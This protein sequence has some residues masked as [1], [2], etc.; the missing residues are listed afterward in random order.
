MTTVKFAPILKR[1]AERHGGL[2]ALEEKAQTPFDAIS[3]AELAKIADDRWLSMISKRVFQAG[4]VW[5]VVENM[6]PPTEEAFEGFDPRRIA[7]YSDE[8]LE[9]VMSSG[10]VMRHGTKLRAVRDNAAF[11]V[12]LA[13]EHGSAAKFFADWPAEDFTGLLELMKKRG[14]RLGGNTGA[15]ILRSMRKPAFILSEDVVRAL[16]WAEI[17]EKRPSA[18]RDMVKVQ[19]AFNAWMAETQR[20]LTQ[21]SR[22]LALSV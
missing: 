4:F 22:I 3:P 15:Y 10:K 16:M 9:R 2:E 7:M 1:A 19:A 11:L 5:K 14:A 13:D 20:D 18:K 17:V 6:W 12:D 8:D 21:I